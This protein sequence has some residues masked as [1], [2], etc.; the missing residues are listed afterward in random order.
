[1][2]WVD[3]PLFCWPW[4]DPRNEQIERVDF[5]G[6]LD[7]KKVQD[8]QTTV[9]FT[10]HAFTKLNWRRQ[11]L[12]G[13]GAE[14]DCLRSPYLLNRKM[15]DCRRII[16]RKYSSKVLL[17]TWYL[18]INLERV[19]KQSRGYKQIVPVRCVMQYHHCVSK[20]GRSRS[21]WLMKI[22]LNHKT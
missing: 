7:I 15:V 21:E 6:H 4:H 10:W 12:D 8:Y 14:R 13:G 17:W 20:I 1:M 18:C 19:R 11:Q 2:A 9:T 5:S 16:I 22:R 3:V